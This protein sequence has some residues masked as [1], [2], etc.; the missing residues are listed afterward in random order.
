MTAKKTP[1]PAP[2][3]IEVAAIPHPLPQ[4][5][6]AYVLTADGELIPDPSE[7]PPA[8]AADDDAKEA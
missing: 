8:D 3:E 2:A 6:G 7:T 1:A 4:R 5:G